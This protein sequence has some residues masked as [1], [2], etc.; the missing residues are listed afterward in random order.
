MRKRQKK[1]NRRKIAGTLASVQQKASAVDARHHS[2]LVGAAS[3]KGTSA[4]GVARTARLRL[5]TRATLYV[6]AP[7]AELPQEHGER[8][9]RRQEAAVAVAPDSQTCRMALQQP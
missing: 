8:R 6:L 2:V 7:G 3:E 1:T 9:C 5:R 4:D